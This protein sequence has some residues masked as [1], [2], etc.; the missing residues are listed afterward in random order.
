MVEQISLSKVSIRPLE[1]AGS[2]QQSA[3]WKVQE[4]PLLL[5]KERQWRF[6]ASGP[7]TDDLARLCQQRFQTR[8]QATQAAAMLVMSS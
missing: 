2:F 7:L 8:L 5:A 6:F 1:P 3:C 4:L